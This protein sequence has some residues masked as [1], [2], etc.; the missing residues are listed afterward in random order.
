M[1]APLKKKKEKV[2]MYEG[3]V[4]HY[5]NPVQSPAGYC[6]FSIERQTQEFGQIMMPGLK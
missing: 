5:L 1:D 3:T 4:N 6:S 2:C